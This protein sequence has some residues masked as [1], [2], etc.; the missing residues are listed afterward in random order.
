MPIYI[1]KLLSVTVL[2]MLYYLPGLFPISRIEFIPFASAT[3]AYAGS[4]SEARRVSRRTAR[5]TTRRVE[6]R[7]DRWERRYYAMPPGHTVVIVGGTKY[8]IHNGYYYRPYFE[9]G[10]VVYIHVD[11]P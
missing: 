6:R 4:R 5:R 10:S 1:K 9:N 3:P 11:T 7:H 8:Y 2:I